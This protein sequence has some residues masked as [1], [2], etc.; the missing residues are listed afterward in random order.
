MKVWLLSPPLAIYLLG[1]VAL[2]AATSIP[3]HKAQASVCR[4]TYGRA[5]AAKGDVQAHS[6]AA[7]REEE[8]LVEATDGVLPLLSNASNASLASQGAG[9][10]ID[11][12]N[13]IQTSRD[14]SSAF[15]DVLSE[16][17]AD[18]EGPGLAR[19]ACIAD[20]ESELAQLIDAYAV[21]GQPESIVATGVTRCD[22]PLKASRGNDPSAWALLTACASEHVKAKAAEFVPKFADGDPLGTLAHTPEQIAGT[23]ASVAHAGYGVCDVL[24]AGQ[25]KAPDALRVRCKAAVAAS[26]ARA[27]VDRLR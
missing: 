2:A 5:R 4:A 22:E 18:I 1:S 8:C 21:G 26:V 27:V 17:S 20:R 6:D 12:P 10:D 9:E 23:F 14:A 16:K 19:I 3:A 13:A 11:V 25:K 15:C 24:T 7:R